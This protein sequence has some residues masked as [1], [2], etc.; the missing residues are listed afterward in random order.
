MWDTEIARET[1]HNTYVDNVVMTARSTEEAT[2][3]YKESKEVFHE[4]NMNLR[5][6]ISNDDNASNT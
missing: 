1:D 2:I 5:E 6:F 3:P 4:M